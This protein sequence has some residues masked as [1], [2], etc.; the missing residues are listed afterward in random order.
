MN[1][2]QITITVKPN[3]IELLRELSDALGGKITPGKIIEVALADALKEY[4][5]ITDKYDIKQ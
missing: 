5:E 2:A 3:Y 1:V 4:P